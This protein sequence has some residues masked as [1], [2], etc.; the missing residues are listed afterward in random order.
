MTYGVHGRLPGEEA[1][2]LGCETLT[3][4]TLGELGGT[5]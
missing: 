1:T 3:V 5:S 4:T 2:T